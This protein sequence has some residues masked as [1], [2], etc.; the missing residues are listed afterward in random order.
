MSLK[1]GY[2]VECFVQCWPCNGHSEGDRY[3]YCY[4][5]SF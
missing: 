3:Y 2:D 4:C 5:Y 1:G